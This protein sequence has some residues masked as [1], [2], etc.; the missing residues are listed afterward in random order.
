MPYGFHPDE[1]Q[2]FDDAVEMMRKGIFRPAS[3]RN[4]PLFNYGILLVLYVV[5]GAQY[6][7][8]TIA[9]LAE[10]L[11]SL[12]R[13]FAFGIARGLAALAGTAICCLLYLLGRRFGGRPAGILVGTFYAVAFLSVRDAHFA[14]NDVPMVSLVTLAFLFALRLLEG[15]GHRDLV[16]GGL[17]AGLAAA[18]KYNGAIA[19]LPLLLAAALGAQGAA[20]AGRV[21]RI[22]R[23]WLALLLLCL[24]GFLLGNPYSIFDTPALLAGVSTQ[25]GLRGIMW[26][27]QSTAPVP[28]LVLQ[29][30]L[31][32]LG[33]PMLLFFPF[34]TAVC[35]ARGGTRAKAAL[36]ALSVVL[37]LLLYHSLQTLFFGRFLLPCTP[38]I[39]LICAWGLVG[40]REASAVSWGRHQFVLWAGVGL[41]IISPLARS[42]YLDVILHRQDTRILAKEYLERVAP[43]RSIIAI[44]RDNSPYFTPPFNRMR[45][46]LLNLPSDSPPP[47]PTMAPA[48]YYIFSSFVTGQMSKSSAA[49]E[50][51]LL[52]ALERHGFA[53]TSISPLR[54]GEAPPFEPDQ[55]YLP[56]HQLFRYERPGPII[57]IY[58]RPGAP[59]PT[60]IDLS[61]GLGREWDRFSSEP[62]RRALTNAQRRPFGSTK[63]APMSFDQAQRG[64]LMEQ[65]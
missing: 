60:S 40:L 30:L 8:G 16:L 24:A 32:E 58:S 13:A 10:F 26:L 1:Y 18:T 41:L 28:L 15:G 6:A 48:D 47:D 35:L 65:A 52:L 54:D 29:T 49:K 38:F 45:Y 57:V 19:L 4:P 33:W 17:T 50:R 46:R 21:A 23:A 3:F 37:P 53:R 56:Y 34:A 62:R 31:T 20:T 22:G 55:V 61:V 39:V 44:I 27:G 2:Y 7:T 11:P 43:S 59:L 5:Y 63:P 51:S 25:Y 12:P 64:S 9:S 42:V 36:L 14:V